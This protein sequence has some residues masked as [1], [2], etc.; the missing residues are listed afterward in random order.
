MERWTSEARMRIN[1]GA[2]A[3]YSTTLVS[4]NLETS[5]V[6][7]SFWYGGRHDGGG[8]R[9]PF[10]GT[11]GQG[12]EFILYDE[13]T[14]LDVRNEWHTIRV[15]GEPDPDG[16]DLTLLSVYIDP[17]SFDDVFQTK[18]RRHQCGSVIHWNRC[19]KHPRAWQRRLRLHA[20]HDSGRVSVVAE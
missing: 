4:S 5:L 7:N 1:E 18:L 6:W 17:E 19:Y 9:R 10:I 15:T 2:L 16:S 3:G 13:A 14:G 20:I 12:T 8:D 11:F